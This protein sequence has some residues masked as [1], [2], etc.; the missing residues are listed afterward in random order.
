MYSISEPH[1]KTLLNDKFN[2][3]NLGVIKYFIGFEVAKSKEGI[4]LCQIKYILDLLQDTCLIG[5]SH[6]LLL[7]NLIY[8]YTRVLINCFLIQLHTN[9]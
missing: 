4:T 9:D 3:K 8:N 2:I 7:C 6:A 5:I 1:I